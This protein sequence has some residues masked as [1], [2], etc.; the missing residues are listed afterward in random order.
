MINDFDS[1]SKF[2]FFNS[3]SKN[4]L[5][6]LL[7]L[8]KKKKTSIQEIDIKELTSQFVEYFETYKNEI[9][10]DQYSDYARMA[11]YLIEL[12]TRSLLPDTDLSVKSQKSYEEERDAFI[13]RLLEYQMYKNAIPLLGKYKEK[14]SFLLDK[15]PEDSDEFLANSVPIA[16]LPKRMNPIKLQEAFEHVLTRNIIKERLESPVD[17]HMVTQEYSVNEV[18]IDLLDNL[19]NKIKQRCLFSYFFSTIPDEK[20]NIDYFCMLFFVILSLIHQNFIFVELVDNDFYIQLNED[21]LKDEDKTINFIESIK[22]ELF[23][24]E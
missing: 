15:D 19:H 7:E 16:K 13:K 10:L 8:I 17:L 14:R 9:S 3:E 20:R 5:D 4:S 24:D 2:D 12:K 22:R 21:L 6:V 11:A 1:E 23:G 18:I